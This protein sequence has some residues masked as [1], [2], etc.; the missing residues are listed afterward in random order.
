MSKDLDTRLAAIDRYFGSENWTSG[1]QVL[2]QSSGWYPSTVLENINTAWKAQCRSSDPT[3]HELSAGLVMED[4]GK[5]DP[6]G[7][8]WRSCVT[9]GFG[10]T[11]GGFHPYTP[12]KELTHIIGSTVVF[13][14]S[15]EKIEVRMVVTWRPRPNGEGG[16]WLITSLKE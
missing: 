3:V 13:D 10:D 2:N 6:G 4:P 14:G 7:R 8:I 12:N 9:P 1:V 15:S 16:H 5:I 11:S